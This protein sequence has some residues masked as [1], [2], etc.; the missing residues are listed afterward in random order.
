MDV[1]FS[2]LVCFCTRAL[3]PRLDFG[4]YV[5][6]MRDGISPEIIERKAFHIL[7]AEIS[8][9]NVS[10]SLVEM[11]SIG[12]R[13]GGQQCAFIAHPLYFS[14][15]YPCPFPSFNN[16]LPWLA[17]FKLGTD[18][19]GCFLMLKNKNAYYQLITMVTHGFAIFAIREPAWSLFNSGG[20]LENIWLEK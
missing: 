13:G 15:S 6:D 16:I 8:S 3:G 5:L 9:W 12:G 4:D 11:G 17:C 19:S 20:Q 10:P 18:C 7:R 14:S 2:F 1:Y